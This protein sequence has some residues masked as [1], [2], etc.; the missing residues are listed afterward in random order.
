LRFVLP[1]RPW[2]R[3]TIGLLSWMLSHRIARSWNARFMWHR[4]VW[5]DD[6]DADIILLG[7]GYQF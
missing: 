1:R 6:R 2:G 3:H 5:D 7:V 4:S